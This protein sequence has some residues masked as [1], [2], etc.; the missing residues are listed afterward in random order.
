MDQRVAEAEQQPQPA[1]RQDRVPEFD[2]LTWGAERVLKVLIECQAETLHFIA[3]RTYSNLEFMRRLR[4][5]TGWQ[6]RSQLQQSWLT[7][8]VAD[9]GKEWGRMVGMSFQHAN[10]DTPLQWLMY[11]P[12]PRGRG[13]AVAD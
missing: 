3:R 9:Y 10:S 4:D 7:D 6:E 8:C 13:N 12:V 11:R 2:A 5:C 1:S